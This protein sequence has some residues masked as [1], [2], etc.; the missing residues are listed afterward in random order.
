MEMNF[1]TYITYIS[2]ADAFTQ[3]QRI[4]KKSKLEKLPYTSRYPW[5]C[6]WVISLLW[7]LVDMAAK[8]R[9]NNS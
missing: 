1:Y 3:R 8:M 7:A 2:L 5:I 6:Y 4:K 9:P